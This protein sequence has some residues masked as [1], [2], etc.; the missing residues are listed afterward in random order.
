MCMSQTEVTLMKFFARYTNYLFKMA[1]VRT[2][3]NACGYLTYCDETLVSLG[4]WISVIHDFASVHNPPHEESSA[5][6]SFSLGKRGNGSPRP[7]RDTQDSAED[8]VEEN[9]EHTQ[10]AA[11]RNVENNF[12]RDRNSPPS[13]PESAAKKPQNWKPVFEYEDVSDQIELTN[14]D[15]QGI[16]SLRFE[17]DEING[18]TPRE[19]LQKLN[20]TLVLDDVNKDKGKRPFW[21]KM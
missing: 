16:V 8:C 13:E 15:I 11:V 21:I 19:I 5:D 20:P 7:S 6:S 2:A 4:H 9:K 17:K 10:G 12:D 3:F 18:E 14:E 1:N